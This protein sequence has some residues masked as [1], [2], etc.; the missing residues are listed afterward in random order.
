MLFCFTFFY[1]TWEMLCYDY[2]I[3]CCVIL[4]YIIWWLFIW[5]YICYK[6]FYIYVISGLSWTTTK[7]GVLFVSCHPMPEVSHVLHPKQ[8]GP[9]TGWWFQIFFIFTPI[10][11]KISNLTNIFQRGWNHQLDRNFV[12]FFFE[13]QLVVLLVLGVSSRWK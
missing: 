6:T 10:W 5:I 8:D 7:N 2:V 4:C 3:W 12:P 9:Y 11:G 13:R 1:V